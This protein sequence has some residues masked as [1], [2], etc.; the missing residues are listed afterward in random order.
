[1]GHYKSNLRDIE[2]NLFEVLGPTAHPGHAARSPTSTSTPRA[3]CSPRSP[4]G[5]GPAGRVLRRRRPQPAGLRPRDPHRHA[6]RVVQEVLPGADGRRVVAARTCPE[7]GGPPARR[8]S[9]WAVGELVLGA[10]PALH[11]YAAGAGVRRRSSTAT[12]PT[13]AEADGPAHG[14]QAAGAPPWCSP[15][16]TP[17]PT[18][19]PGAPRP[20]Q[21]PD[22]SWH[23]EGVKR[24]ITSGEHD[25]TDNI[26]HLVLAR[27]GGRRPRHQGPVAVPRAEVPL[28]PRDRRARRAQRR[29]RDQ[30]RAQDGP[31]GLHHLR[32]HLRRAPD[33][34]AVGWLV[35]DV[36]D[37]IAQMFQVIE[38]RPDDGRH[39][40]DRDAVHRLPQR[41]GVRQD[42]GAG[43]RPDPDCA[44]R[45]RRA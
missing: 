22:G 2:F 11:M 34:P 29:V 10:N 36:H 18:S 45:P 16:R 37:G 24:F 14:R 33:V 15:S 25:L 5:R 7:L 31:Q 13:D 44:T 8:A 32:A 40:G 38:I 23:I 27:P 3:A 9:C 26:M 41:P 20:S 12:A 39:Q 42:A 19:A 4:A 35:G 21:Q 28:R 17:A 30:R 1:M 6:A 43:R